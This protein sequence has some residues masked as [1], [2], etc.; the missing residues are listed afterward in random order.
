MKKKLTLFASLSTL[1]LL[2]S[3][4]VSFGSSAIDSSHNGDS[5]NGTLSSTPDVKSSEDENSSSELNVS[6]SEKA[7]ESSAQS[8]TSSEFSSSQS[9]GPSYIPSGYS[10]AWSDEFDGTSLDE[11]A[12]SYQIGNGMGDTG[13][14]N[15]GW[16]NNEQQCYEKENTTVA[17]GLLTIKAKKESVSYWGGNY[18]YTS[19]RLRTYQKKSFTYGYFEAK[20]K[21]PEVTGL[22]PAFWMLPEENFN[23]RGW[24]TNGEIDIMEARGRQPTMVGATTHTANS[25]YADHYITKS[26]ILDSSIGNW[27]TY[28][29][30]WDAKA[31]NFYADGSIYH[32]VTAAEWAGNVSDYNGGPAPFDRNFHLILN[33]A[34]GGNYDGG[35]MPPSDFSS[36]DMVVD[37]VRAYQK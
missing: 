26:T 23:N 8:S 1:C 9:G 32:S 25:S 24:P 14:G 10:L 6:S 18:Q 21:L 30:L 17:D 33:L 28:G 11:S 22:W 35:Q 34:V 4:T 20:I 3:C 27:H 2:S 7:S 13:N 19:S 29:V 12:W 36:G 15:W 16:G 5:S 37:Y 31:L